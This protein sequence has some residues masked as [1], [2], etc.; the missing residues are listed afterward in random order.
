TLLITLYFMGITSIWVLV[1]LYLQDG[2]GHSA[3][4]SGLVG[5]PS[6]VASTFA[7]LWGGR[8]VP[9]YGRLVVIGGMYSALLG[10]AGSIL[11]VWLRAGAHVSEWWLILTL[12]FVGIGQGT[13][14]SPNQALTLADVPLRY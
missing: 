1:A 2:L 8:N 9:T 5:L 12:T 3:L 14:I 4:A 11:V 7:A 10:V 13:V 6:A